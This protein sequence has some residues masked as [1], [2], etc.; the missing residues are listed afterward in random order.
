MLNLVY[1]RYFDIGIFR[2]ISSILDQSRLVGGTHGFG[3]KLTN[4]FSSLFEIETYSHKKKT[5]Y[6]QQWSNNMYDVN[7]PVLTSMTFSEDFTK[8]TF[9]PD[10]ARFG[11][12]ESNTDS[13]ENIEKFRNNTSLNDCTNIIDNTI[14]VFKRR[15]YDMTATLPGVSFTF[16]DEKIPITSFSEYVEMFSTKPL[17]T[18]MDQ[19]FPVSVPESN[20]IAGEGEVEEGVKEINE[21]EMVGDRIIHCKVNPRWEVAV[22]RSATG[23]FEQ[24][25]FVNNVWTPKGGSHVTLV[26]NQVR[27]GLSAK[28]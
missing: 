27:I 4:I 13:N 18:S 11:I 20:C 7:P 23:S 3:A 16:N 14:E 17:M 24:V 12:N 9:E 8:V 5:L 2:K 22:K 6:R 26:T 19:N 15:T 1:Y 28:T 25:S 21:N 10:L